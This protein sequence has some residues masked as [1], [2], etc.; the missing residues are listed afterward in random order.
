ASGVWCSDAPALDR[1]RGEVGATRDDLNL[2]ATSPAR[3]PSGARGPLLTEGTPGPGRPIDPLEGAAVQG[4]RACPSKP[5]APAPR[6]YVPLLTGPV[7]NSIVEI[8]ASRL[9]PLA[10]L[11]REQAYV[12]FYEAAARVKRYLGVS[13]LPPFALSA[14]H[15][16]GTMPHEVQSSFYSRSSVASGV[17]RRMRGVEEWGRHLCSGTRT[18]AKSTYALTHSSNLCEAWRTLIAPPPVADCSGVKCPAG[19]NRRLE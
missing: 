16:D 13:L 5:T 10:P 17:R 6:G 18:A 2:P 12:A 14:V 15:G 3:G 7:P 8:I 1:V 9:H 11:A 19:G 4:L